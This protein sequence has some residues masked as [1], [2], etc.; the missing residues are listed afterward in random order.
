MPEM[1]EKEL[2]DSKTYFTEGAVYNFYDLYF[3][4]EDLF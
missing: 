4:N 2:R 3:K 1:L